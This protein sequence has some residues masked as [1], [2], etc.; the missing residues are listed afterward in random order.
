VTTRVLNAVSLL[1]LCAVA[2]FALAADPGALLAQLDEYPHT[3]QVAATEDAVIDHEVGLGALQKVS[4]AWDFKDSER[5]SGTLTRYTWQVIDGFTS[6]EV[7]DT[8]IAAIKKG[9]DSTLLYTCDG[10]ACGHGAQWANRI[11]R[12]RLLY[13]RQDL[14]FYRVYAVGEGGEDRLLVYASARSSDRQYLHVE[15]LATAPGS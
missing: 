1:L 6:R 3:A 15:W 7:M 12:Q 9:G 2:K 4:G 10:R 14:Q 13:G 5:L 8:L 11:F